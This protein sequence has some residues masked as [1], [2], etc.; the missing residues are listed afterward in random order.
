MDKAPDRGAVLKVFIDRFHP[1]SWS[2][3]LASIIEENTVLLDELATEGY[4]SIA[5]LI[6]DKKAQLVQEI[7]RRRRWEIE[8]ES[9][10]NGHSFKRPSPCHPATIELLKSSDCPLDSNNEHTPRTSVHL[11]IGLIFLSHADQ[12]SAKRRVHRQESVCQIVA[13]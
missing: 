1:M 2:G 7:E 6:R 13:G 12:F 8:R 3:S 11:K 4:P 5:S 9:E 10:Q